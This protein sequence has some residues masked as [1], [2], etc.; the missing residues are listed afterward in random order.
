MSDT[1]E[2]LPSALLAYE[3]VQEQAMELADVTPLGRATR[4]D[5]SRVPASLIPKR[6]TWAQTEGTPLPLGA[7]WIADERPSILRSMR[8]MSKRGRCE[9]AGVT[10]ATGD[11]VRTSRGTEDLETSI[12]VFGAA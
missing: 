3:R 5:T 2:Q 4:F 7:T 8:S 12:R 1:V 6:T 11:C 10:E 9:N